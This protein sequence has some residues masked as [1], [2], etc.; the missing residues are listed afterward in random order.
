[1][2][3]VKPG[4][5]LPSLDSTNADTLRENGNTWCCIKKT[6][7][8]AKLDHSVLIKKFNYGEG[9]QFSHRLLKGIK[10]REREREGCNR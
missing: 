7:R 1:M 8:D 9:K 5:G 10:R 4:N 6:V 3:A 2:R